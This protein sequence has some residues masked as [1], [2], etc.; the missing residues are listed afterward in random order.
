MEQMYSIS[1]KSPAF[2]L[3]LQFVRRNNTKA[4]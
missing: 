3:R 2:W 1:D 4:N